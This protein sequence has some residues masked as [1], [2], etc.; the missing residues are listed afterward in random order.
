M[1]TLGTLK[2]ID[3]LRKVW[4]LEDKDFSQW[5]S[6]KE[7]LELLSQEIGINLSL[8]ETEARTGNFYVDILAHEEET[9]KKVIIENQLE[10]TNHDHLGKIITYA[11]GY[12]AEYII[13]IVKDF[14]DEHKQALDWLN[15]NTNE[16]IN[17]F[18]IKMELW[19][20][21]NSSYAPKFHV[22]SQ[23][24]QWSK[25]IRKG[26]SSNT[27]S[28]TGLKQLR[29][30]EDFITHCKENGTSLQ[31]GRPQPS[32]PAYYN[33]GI[34]TSEGSIAVKFNLYSKIVKVEFYFKSKDTYWPLKN[35][36]KE[37]VVKTFTSKVIYDD[38]EKYKG[39]TMGFHRQFQ[40]DDEKKW[41]GYFSWMKEHA[42]ELQNKIPGLLAKAKELVPVED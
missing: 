23:P 20:I 31:L 32:A 37:E 13:W 26:Q 2:R 21:D 15:E 1:I 35:E 7:N 3:D 14:R 28:E 27:I 5:L 12:E 24:N 22:V 10:R 18:G 38:L 11:S 42:E 34:G 16:K 6:Q 4:K 19:Q 33:I 29:F 30:T 40:I 8:Q 17:F 39:A 41:P 25:A 9:G 36:L